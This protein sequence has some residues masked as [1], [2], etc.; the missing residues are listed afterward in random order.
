M[1]HLKGMDAVYFCLID[2]INRII[3][4]FLFI[5]PFQ[6]TQRKDHDETTSGR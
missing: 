4:I 3:G 5:T 2:R 6:I 1:D